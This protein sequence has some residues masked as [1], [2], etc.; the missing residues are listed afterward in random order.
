M[1]WELISQ[2]G[3]EFVCPTCG[4]KASVRLKTVKKVCKECGSVFKRTC[5]KP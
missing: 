4:H 2:K 3:L 1:A 5:T